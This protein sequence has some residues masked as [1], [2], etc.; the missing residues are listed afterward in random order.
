MNPLAIPQKYYERE[1]FMSTMGLG[2]TAAL[3]TIGFTVWNMISHRSISIEMA[4]ALAGGSLATWGY[5][6]DS[7]LNYAES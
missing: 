5:L 3:A 7:G 4:A 2:Y 6:R 1:G